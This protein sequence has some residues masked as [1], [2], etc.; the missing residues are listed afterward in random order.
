[1]VETVV[2]EVVEVVE[3]VEDVEVVARV[4]GEIGVV[5]TAGSDETCS[6][7]G[8]AQPAARAATTVRPVSPR[9]RG[10][11]EDMSA[12]F[13]LIVGHSGRWPPEAEVT[14]PSTER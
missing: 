4:G 9:T 13:P 6:S 5:M 10:N 2:V 11:D 7:P 12:S 3:D 14:T 1:M 8:L